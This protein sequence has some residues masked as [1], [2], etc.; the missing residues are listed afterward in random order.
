MS[1]LAAVIDLSH[2]R[3]RRDRMQDPWVTKKVVADH[4][5]VTERTIERWQSDLRYSRGGGKLLP[6]RKLYACSVRYRLSEVD[7]WLELP[8]DPR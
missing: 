5:G 6:H 7:A 8:E 1:Q 3:K 2:E 4:L